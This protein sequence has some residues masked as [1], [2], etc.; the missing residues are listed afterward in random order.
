MINKVKL[1]D[2]HIQNYNRQQLFSELT[3]GLVVTPNVDIIIKARNDVAFRNIINAA[4]FSLCDS[5]IVQLASRFLGTPLVEKISG[6]DLLGEFCQHHAQNPAIRLFLL[7]AA[8]GVALEAMRRINAR[9][10]RAIVV[11][12]HSPSFGFENKADECQAIVQKIEASGATV[13]IVGVGAP[14]QEKWIHAHR[15]QLPSIRIFMGLGATLDF[16]AGNIQRA[17]LWMS[18]SGLEW[19]YRLFK[20]PKRLWR[21]YLLD[22]IPF[23]WH[24]LKQRLGLYRSPT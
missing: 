4:E 19:S 20:E 16:E 7:G 12:A 18:Q 6:S 24:L 23:F 1:L 15:P 13:L 5:K 22:D 9:I 21:R 2:V 10:G 17:P 14:K 8:E 3:Y 11:A